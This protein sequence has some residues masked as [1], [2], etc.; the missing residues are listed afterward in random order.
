MP[1]TLEQFRKTK[2]EPSNFPCWAVSETTRKLYTFII[3]NYNQIKLNIENSSNLSPRDRQLIARRIAVQCGFS[4]SIITDRR[5]PNIVDLIKELNADLAIVFKSVSAKKWQS[6]RKL[7]KEELIKE[8]KNLKTENVELRKLSLGAFATAI[9]ESSI[10]ADTRS[11]TLTIDKL[12]EE[13]ERQKTVIDN[14]AEQNRRY[15]ES[16]SK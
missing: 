14:Q 16:L 7:T 12:K 1:V 8:N 9:L 5:Q 3:E 4:P 13:I 10:L 15:M 2:G 6:G 11:Y